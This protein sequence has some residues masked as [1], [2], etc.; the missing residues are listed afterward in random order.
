LE[1][2]LAAFSSSPLY[3]LINR[4]LRGRSD[5]HDP[6]FNA[7]RVGS[8]ALRNFAQAELPTSEHA[9]DAWLQRTE[10]RDFD[11]VLQL[12]ASN[13]FAE[14]TGT[15]QALFVDD[16]CGLIGS[17]RVRI[18]AGARPDEVVT[19]VLR[20]ASSYQASGIILATNDL[21]G[22]IATAPYCSKLT[23]DIYRKGEAIAIFLLDHFVLT[24]VG[25]RRMFAL[26]AAEPAT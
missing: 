18:A 16:R 24:A 20:V 9:D 10:L 11:G 25:W 15:M 14:Q 4:I 19:E 8:S 5:A 1:A 2:A 22:E 13:G 7:V 12:L 23:W 3:S 26:P 6:V 21:R 17:R